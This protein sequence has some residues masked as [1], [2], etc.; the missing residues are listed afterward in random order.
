[1]NIFN[2]NFLRSFDESPSNFSPFSF[3]KKSL[4]GKSKTAERECLILQLKELSGKGLSN[5]DVE[6]ALKQGVKIPE[7][8]EEL[9]FSVFNTVSASAF[10]FSSSSILTRRLKLI[11][12]HIASHYPLYE[13]SQ[14]DDNLFT[15]KFLFA[16]DTSASLWGATRVGR[17]VKWGSQLGKF[18]YLLGTS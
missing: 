17:G 16:I 7:S 12:S 1:M 6:S 8:I 15:A 13:V 10:F 5:E 11:H 3:P 2:G 4:F 18:F 9:R 14:L